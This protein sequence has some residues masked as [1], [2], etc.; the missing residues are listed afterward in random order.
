MYRRAKSS[1]LCGLGDLLSCPGVIAFPLSVRVVYGNRC[2]LQKVSVSMDD[3][4]FRRNPAAAY[5]QGVAEAVQQRQQEALREKIIEENKH[6]FPLPGEE[7]WSR[8]GRPG[9]FSRLAAFFVGEPVPVRRSPCDTDRVVDTTVTELSPMTLDQMEAEALRMVAK[10]NTGIDLHNVLNRVVV[11]L[12]KTFAPFAVLVLTIPESMWVFTHLY[13]NPDAVL[14]T[15]TGIFAVLVDFGYLYLTVLLAMNKEAL[16]QRRRAGIEVEAH[17]RWV[18]RVQT[19]L[20]WIV[21]PTDTLAQVVFLYSATK[22][23]TFFAYSLVLVL[24]AVR[25][26]SLFLT[27]FVVSFAG[28]ELMTSVDRVANQQVE[29]AKATGR[30]MDALGMARLARQRARADLQEELEEQELRQEGRRLLSEIYADARVAVRRQ[31]PSPEPSG[32]S[33]TRIISSSRNDNR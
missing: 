28:T 21:A 15:V 22:D 19:A 20:W 32:P 17:E 8:G 30:V 25:V 9:F 12:F 3:E 13:K 5:T 11:F 33:R 31:P 6:L 10:A 26:F 4:L 16:F 18:V 23:S 29:R 24:V 14:V 2:V 27:M 1:L 7:G